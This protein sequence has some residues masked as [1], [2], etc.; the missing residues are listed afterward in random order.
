[1]AE[2]TKE[3]LEF[4]QVIEYL[5]DDKVRVYTIE[6]AHLGDDNDPLTTIIIKGHRDVPSYIQTG[7]EGMLDE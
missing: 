1:M 4:V 7:K 2:L 5:D 3:E 6:D